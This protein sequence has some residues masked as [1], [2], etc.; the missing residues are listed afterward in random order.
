MHCLFKFPRTVVRE[1]GNLLN[2]SQNTN[3]DS[4]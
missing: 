2:L 3:I 1:S 4:Q